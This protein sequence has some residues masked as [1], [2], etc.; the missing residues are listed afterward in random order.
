MAKLF[1]NLLDGSGRRYFSALESAP[2]SISPATAIITLG[3]QSPIAVQHL[4]VF[5]NPAT[6][7]LNLVGLSLA[8]QPVLIP[9][10]AA[11]AYGGLAVSTTIRSLTISPSLPQIE[12][13]E[14][15]FTPSLLTQMTASPAPAGI[16]L[17]VRQ[18]AVNQGGN[19]GFVFP[20]VAAIT[21]N[22]LAANF[23][24]DVIGQSVIEIVGHAPQLTSELILYPDVG[25]VSLIDTP[26][27][28][29]LPFGWVD[30]DPAPPVVWVGST[31]GSS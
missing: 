19:I 29:A 31:P 5:R 24:F 15:D 21:L 14:A 22:G 2:G 13:P 28:V 16:V 3:G 27:N 9:A 23:V 12:A 4:T 7:T 6:L 20:G 8:P 26:P 17:E 1:D 25:M 10:P 18:H 11:L 30:A